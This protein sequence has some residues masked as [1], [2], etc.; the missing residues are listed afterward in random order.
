M[1]PPLLSIENISKHY[2]AVQ[3]LRGVSFD[4]HAGEVLHCSAT[5]AP[6]SRR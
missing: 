5:M 6:A 4:V 1:T 3:A 2:G